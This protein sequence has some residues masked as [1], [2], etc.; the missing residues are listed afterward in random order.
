MTTKPTWQSEYELQLQ[1]VQCEAPVSAAVFLGAPC[2]FSLSDS[3]KSRSTLNEVGVGCQ[4]TA[5]YSTRAS[6]AIKVGFHSQIIVDQHNP[7]K[8]ERS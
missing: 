7:N 5:D 6:L 2:E 4:G 3:G 8:R 1:V